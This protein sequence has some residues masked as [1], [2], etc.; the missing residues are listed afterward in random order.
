MKIFKSPTSQ[1]K[2][3]IK[4]ITEKQNANLQT[5]YM[6]RNNIW[7]QLWG[8]TKKPLLKNL[9]I[10]PIHKLSSPHQCPTICQ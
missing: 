4:N 8:Y 1:T 7:K 5:I 3:K 2:I 9:L 10:I 6:L